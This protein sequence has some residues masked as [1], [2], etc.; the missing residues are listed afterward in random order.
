M[1]L[2]GS[3]RDDWTSS[4]GLRQPLH[5]PSG[6]ASG[7]LDQNLLAHSP[8][9]STANCMSPPQ[10]TGLRSVPTGGREIRTS[11]PE[12]REKSSGGTM[13]VPVIR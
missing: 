2:D 9:C 6:Y 3:P 11:S 1:Q 4:F 10:A 13:P 5:V 12:R 8:R 7:F